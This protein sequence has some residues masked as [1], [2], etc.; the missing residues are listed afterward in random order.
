MLNKEQ[1]QLSLDIYLK[2]FICDEHEA[3]HVSI[4]EWY[5]FNVKLCLCPQC[6]TLNEQRSGT[7]LLQK[8]A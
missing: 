7:D 5:G 4:F 8:V 1:K 2:C 3:R 6:F